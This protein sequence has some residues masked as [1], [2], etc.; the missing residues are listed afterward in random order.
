MPTSLIPVRPTADSALSLVNWAGLTHK[1]MLTILL[2]VVLVGAAI[3]GSLAVLFDHL[4]IR[5]D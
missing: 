1:P 3:I 2:Q 5:K 4:N